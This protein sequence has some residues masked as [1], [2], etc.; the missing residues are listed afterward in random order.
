MLR[1][2]AI[3]TSAAGFGSRP[4]RKQQFGRGFSRRPGRTPP[5]RAKIPAQSL[6]ETKTSRTV[7]AAPGPV[8]NR[9][10]RH[11]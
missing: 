7:A 1:K 5:N 6:M 3:G 2:W 4:N 11:L 8:M 10:A 9:T